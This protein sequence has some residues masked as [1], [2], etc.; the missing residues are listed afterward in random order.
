MQK[1]MRRH[2]GLARSKIVA[3]EN[4]ELEAK[5]VTNPAKRK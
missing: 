2:C 5:P 1:L 3:L 4:D